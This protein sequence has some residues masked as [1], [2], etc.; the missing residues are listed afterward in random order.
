MFVSTLDTLTSIIAGVVIFSVLGNLAQNLG[1]KIEDVA[2]GGVSLAFVVYPEAI[3][4]LP[5]GHLWGVMFFL[6]LFILGL[7]SEFA[8]LETV[9]TALYDH[10]PVLRPKR[11]WVT[12]VACL[13][14]FILALP[15]VTNVSLR[16]GL[17]TKI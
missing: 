3:S 8:L 13:I 10:Y 16:E 9:L 4:N 2:K 17:E 5:V 11:L 14:C 6:M 1:V 12:A 15:C 7:D